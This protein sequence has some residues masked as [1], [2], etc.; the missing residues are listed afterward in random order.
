M[1]RLRV[2]YYVYK[3]Q[4]ISVAAEDL[5][6][7]PSA[8]SQQLKKLEEELRTV[9]FTR[10]HKRLIPT[11]SANRLFEIV[12]PL[13]EGLQ[14]SM[15][16]MDQERNEP[17]G[18]I[19]FGAP[20]IFGGS[21]ITRLIGDFREKYDKVTFDMKLGRPDKLARLVEQ[22]DIDFAFID[23]FPTKNKKDIWSGLKVTPLLE[24]RVAL[25]CS[26]EYNES[27]L[28]NDH[29][30]ESL[31]KASYLTQQYGKLSIKKWFKHQFDAKVEK[32]HVILNVSNHKAIMTA[33][34]SH[35]GLGIIAPHLVQRLV[36]R[37]EV[38]I[39]R[40]KAKHPTNNISIL[41]LANKPE[42]MR[43]KLFLNHII[44]AAKKISDDSRQT[45]RGQRLGLRFIY[46]DPIPTD[47]PT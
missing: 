21:H 14:Q 15:E 17:S 10:F 8:V 29:S 34:R 42:T 27:V 6:V 7:T 40:E 38:I 2:F 20:I 13:M 5:F 18:K 37:N 43:E 47:D 32:V 23:D 35:L 41:K 30:L 36:K 24:E 19:T 28:K 22:G 31:L 3:C 26:R 44:R 16:Q 39:I 45:P 12:A 9:L 4:G 1:N 25:V 11:S 46:P 33:V